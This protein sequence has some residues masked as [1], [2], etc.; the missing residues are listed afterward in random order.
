MRDVVLRTFSSLIILVIG[1]W[2]PKS[3]FNKFPSLTLFGPGGLAEVGFFVSKLA[4]LVYGA[5]ALWSLRC[6]FV[7][8]RVRQPK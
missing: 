3:Y 1:Y 4:A 5:M 6:A 7:A 2:A 8:L